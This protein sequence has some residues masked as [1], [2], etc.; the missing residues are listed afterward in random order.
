MP[1]V[2][3]VATSARVWPPSNGVAV[4]MARPDAMAAGRYWEERARRFAAQGQG[5]RAVCSYGMPWFYNHYIHLTQRAALRDWLQ[6]PTDTRVLEL[7]C[8]VGRW[9]RRLAR[10]G[11]RVTGV[12][13]SPAM[14][15][16]AT[17]RAK[18]EGVGDRCE[19]IE[20]DAAEL[21]LGRLFERILCVTVVQHIVDPE[22]MHE[23]LRRMRAHLAPGGRLVLLEAAPSLPDTRCD[24]GTFVA[25]S[26]KTYR[27]AFAKAG[28][29]CL[30]MSGVDPLPLKSRF[31]PSYARL[32][33]PLANAALLAVTA[34]SLPC[35]LALARVL[36]F[37]SW[38]KVFVLRAS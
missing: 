29:R 6:P 28:L 1:N 35:D 36:P 3:P 20:G 4:A 32:P 34:I 38:H 37:P 33:R 9:S 17:R 16:E 22:R 31:L 18:A 15:A 5:L 24:S 27:E 30:A 13:L 19:F 23:A 8:G 2:E 25:R 10:A 7:G 11:I 12:D 14:V 21:E 26:E